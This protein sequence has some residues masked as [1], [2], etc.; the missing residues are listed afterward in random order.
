M[1]RIDS[2]PANVVCFNPVDDFSGIFVSLKFYRVGSSTVPTK[3]ISSDS[4]GSSEL[5]PT[6]AHAAS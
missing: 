2:L 6:H 4:A 1:E 3:R 5:V